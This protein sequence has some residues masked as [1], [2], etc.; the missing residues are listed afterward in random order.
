MILTIKKILSGMLLCGLACSCGY[1]FNGILQEGPRETITIP[2]IPGDAK[3]QLNASLVEAMSETGRYEYQ[4][5]DGHL[6]L[7]AVIVS[8]NS[9]RIDFRFDREPISGKRKKNLIA[10]G[11]RRT[12][13]AEVTLIDTRTDEVLFG[14]ITVTASA[15]FDYDNTDVF[16]D[17]VFLPPGG[18][19]QTMIDFSLGQL[20]SIEG[21][22]DVS[23]VPVYHHLAQ[24]IVDSIMNL[25]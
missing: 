13:A 17:L 24:K 2:Y 10:I 11:N 22:H 15:D 5:N 1:H 19:P 21:A 8:D 9:E 16:R 14:P 7:K 25:D 20:D 4:R 23:D 18:P 6:L 12:A 3:G